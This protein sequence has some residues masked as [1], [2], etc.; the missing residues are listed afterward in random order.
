MKMQKLLF[1]VGVVFA[2]FAPKADV[3]IDFHRDISP[4]LVG[5]DLVGYSFFSKD[6]YQVPN[7]T[8]QVVLRVSKLV[9]KLGEKEKFNSNA[10]VLTFTQSDKKISIEPNA[11]ILKV[12]QAEQFN[13]TPSFL[14]KDSQGN[15]VITQVAVLPSLGGIS[16]DY[17]KELAKFNAK[18][19][20]ELVLAQQATVA[21]HAV[22]STS[23]SNEGNANLPTNEGM[24][25][26]WLKQATSEEIE[27]F[28]ELALQARN[29]P[30][31][32][33]PENATQ[34]VQM[35]SYWFNKATSE[36]RKKVLAYLV[37]L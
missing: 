8:N 29:H 9:E 37:S 4:I 15:T 1:V 24:M 18:Y 34:S 16:R 17:E 3:D 5:E 36:E 30:E 12:E 35:L 7:G 33:V 31:L 6:S 19:Y 25:E 2:S 11:K 10:F 23:V 21:S 14:V 28:T 27:L 22:E 32:I 20:P 26:Y 13:K